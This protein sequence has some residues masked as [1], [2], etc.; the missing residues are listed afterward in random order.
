MPI[1]PTTRRGFTQQIN[2]NK[3]CHSQK[4]LLGISLIRFWKKGSRQLFKQTNGQKEDPRTLRAANSEMTSLLNKDEALNKDFFRAPLRSG[5]MSR[6]S[7]SRNVLMRD[8]GAAHTLYP[9]LQTCGVT[10]RVVRGFTLL[11]LLVVVLIIGILAAVAL[12][13]Y[14]KAVEKA[15]LTEALILTDTVMQAIDRYILE[16]GYPS[17]TTEFLGDGTNCHDCLDITLNNLDCDTGDDYYCEGKDFYYM[18]SC[19]KWQCSGIAIRHN[20]NYDLF[21]QKKS[22]GT[23]NKNCEYGNATG[24]AA[25]NIISSMGWN[26]VKR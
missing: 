15:R 11:E 16:N 26:P 18:A 4:S 7:S 21:W 3:N 24:Q 2:Q 25:C 1:T 14:Q 13:Q 9:A 23:V 19:D 20:S 17:A 12:P 6:P 22:D 8:I 10:E 5:F